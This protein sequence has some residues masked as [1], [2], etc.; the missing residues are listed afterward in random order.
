MKNV[1]LVVGMFA[2]LGCGALQAQTV[3]K[4]DIPFDFQ[5]GRVTMPA[6][7]YRI[8]RTNEILRWQCFK[9]GKGAYV[10]AMPMSGKEIRETGRLLFSRYGDTYFFAKMWLP[11]SSEGA[12]VPPSPR[13]K[14]LARR[15]GAADA[16]GVAL[17]AAR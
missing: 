10:I 1:T 12:E 16:A 5:L 13:E 11:N 6:G 4:A 17:S 2:A 9:A 7:E 8:V 15:V 3:V 14:E